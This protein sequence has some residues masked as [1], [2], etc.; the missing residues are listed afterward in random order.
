MRQVDDKTLSVL[1]LPVPPG[2][3][4]DGDGVIKDPN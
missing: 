4:Y 2:M 3:A 1:D